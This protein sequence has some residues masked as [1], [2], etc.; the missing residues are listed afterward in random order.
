MRVRRPLPA[1]AS[2]AEESALLRGNGG[3]LQFVAQL[4]DLCQ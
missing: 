4:P 1:L 3:G 2:D